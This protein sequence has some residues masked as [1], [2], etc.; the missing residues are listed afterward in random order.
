M[1]IQTKE[2]DNYLIINLEGRIDGLTSADFQ[3]KVDQLTAEGH[4]K[5]ILDFSRVIFMSSAGLR[6]IIQITRSLRPIGGEVILMTLPDQV[7]ELFRVSG[8]EPFLKVVSGLEAI[9]PQSASGP[10]EAIS[11]RLDFGEFAVD[12]MAMKGKTCRLLLFGD[13]RKLASS[14]YLEHDCHRV[15]PSEFRFGAG[16]AALG[17]DYNDFSNLFGETVVTDH[18]FFSFPA[19][20]RPG[21]DYAFYTAE[22]DHPFNFLYGFGF[23]GD[24]SG[25]FRFDFN[26]DSPDLD[27]LLKAAAT[28]AS[29]PVF[30]V[31][32]LGVSQ[33][34]Q[35]MHLKKVP[36]LENQPASGNIFAADIFHTWMNFS[37]EREELN[38]TVIM[39]GLV[40]RDP[41]LIPEK[42]RSFI[43]E[44]G[45]MHLHGIVL[46]NGLLSR[47]LRDFETELAR[48]ARDFQAEKVVHLLPSSRLKSGFIGIINLDLH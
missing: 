22:A 39:T 41:E 29:S 48:V 47:D 33:G 21:V 4:L 5:L 42:V 12:W 30:G 2:W 37:P 35:W 40:S 8:M 14:A 36:V 43:P 13:P 19:V 25:V 1:N 16:L 44:N 32:M 6:V 9:V 24:F 11:S 3:R 38:K 20:T 28:M 46:E 23:P 26:G 7:R 45:G 10:G 18:H 34:L 17:D 31:V 27:Q 15:K